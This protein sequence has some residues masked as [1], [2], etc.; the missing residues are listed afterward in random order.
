VIEQQ[1]VVAKKGKKRGKSNAPRKRRKAIQLL[2]E[3]EQDDRRK[4]GIDQRNK[5]RF[6]ALVNDIIPGFE[7]ILAASS[8]AK[9]RDNL[10]FMRFML[11]R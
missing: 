11:G 2:E 8:L 5:D 4:N 3:A 7:R 9:E 1:E 6:R 10:A